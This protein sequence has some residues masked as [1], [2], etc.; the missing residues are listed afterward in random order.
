MDQTVDKAKQRLIESQVNPLTSKSNSA[1]Q[2]D[3]LGEVTLSDLPILLTINLVLQTAFLKSCTKP[4]SLLLLGKLGIGKSRLLSPLAN[5]DFVS[6]VNDIKNP[7]QHKQ[8]IQ[9]T[10]PTKE[11]GSVSNAVQALEDS[12]YLE[13][14]DAVSLKNVKIK[15]YR[16][17]KE[18][19]EYAL[20]NNSNMDFQK[21]FESNKE[22]FPIFDFYLKQYQTLGHDLFKKF[23]KLTMESTVI[24]GSAG[25]K[26]GIMYAL[27]SSFSLG[28]DLNE[29]EKEKLQRNTVKNL[30]PEY[31]KISTDLKRA[32][33]KR[34]NELL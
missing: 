11:Y 34:I 25:L 21:T 10:M 4:I 1:Y 12:G 20:A 16:C 13:H 18:G 24:A 14:E 26:K 15:I 17:T 3:F 28:E 27:I 9:K 32:L 30:P 23:L 2:G 33:V 8:A 7:S 19:L 5:L 6:Y 31:K 29:E 22:R